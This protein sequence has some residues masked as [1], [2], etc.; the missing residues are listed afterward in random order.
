MIFLFYPT[1]HT[2][3]GRASVEHLSSYEKFL[4]ILYRIGNFVVSMLVTGK[5]NTS[6]PT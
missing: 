6:R 4:A 1:K 5:C 3:H 2:Q